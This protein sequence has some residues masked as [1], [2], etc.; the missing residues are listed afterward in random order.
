MKSIVHPQFILAGN[1]E[2]ILRF[3][4]YTWGVEDIYVARGAP[5]PSFPSKNGGGGQFGMNEK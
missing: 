5:V 4:R 1:E 3:I 2:A